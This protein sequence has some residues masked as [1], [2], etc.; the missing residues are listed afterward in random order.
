MDPGNTYGYRIKAR[1]AQGLSVQSD[2]A[3]VTTLVAP[4]T[5]TAPSFADDT[6]GAQSWTPNTAITPVPVPAASGSPTPTYAAVGALPAG[7]SFSPSARVISGTPT[8][9]R[10]GNNYRIRASNSEGSDDWTV[11]YSTAVAATP[12]PVI[13]V[14][15]DFDNDGTFGHAAADVTVDLVKYSLRATRGRTLQSRRKATA[16]RL[17]CKLWNLNAKYD[18]INTASADLWEGPHRRSGTCAAG[19]GDRVGRHLR[20]AAISQPAHPAA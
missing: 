14:Q 2:F 4:I 18:P 20:Y 8:A 6:G 10:L 15:I 19:W 5:D 13:S 9:T 7:I 17:E 16:G 1:N 3:S 12:L 11:A